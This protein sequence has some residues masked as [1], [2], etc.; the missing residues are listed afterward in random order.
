MAEYKAISTANE[1]SRLE[2]FLFLQGKSVSNIHDD[3]S[4]TLWNQYP[5][6]STVKN[7]VAKFKMGHLSTNDEEH[8]GQPR[9]IVLEKVDA[10]HNLILENCRISAK[11]IANIIGISC[12]LVFVIIHKHLNMKKLSA[13][14]VPKC[15]TTD[16]KSMRVKTSSFI[17]Q[18]F[19]T[20]MNFLD[21][22][23]SMYET[24]IYLYDPDTEEQ[25]EEG[26]HSGSPGPKMFKVQKLATKVMMTSVFWDKKGIM[27]VNYLQNGSTI[28]SRY[29]IE[30][31]DQL[32]A[33]LKAK[34]SGKLC[35]GIL[36]LQY[37][38]S[39]HTAQ[40]T[41]A[42]LGELGFQLVDHLPYSPD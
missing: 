36:S 40:A 28:I 9:V 20:I 17:C 41:M 12:E 24:W 26:R 14:W 6:Y 30:C 35:K 32:K 16:Q 15:L 38:A 37:N 19:K 18:H 39:T 34:R 5:L 11:G 29:Y 13:K 27:L 8:L 25:S 2:Q 22:L 10:L 3:M 42:K 33:T 4:Q 7:W 31:L 1:S 21:Q 23:V